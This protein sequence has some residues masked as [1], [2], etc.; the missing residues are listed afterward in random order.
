MP[1]GRFTGVI[2]LRFKSHG[3]SI[4][5][6]VNVPLTAKITGDLA[7]IPSL[8]LL[9]A[10][11][12]KTESTQLKITSKKKLLITLLTYQ[13]PSGVKVESSSTAAGPLELTVS[14]NAFKASP[15]GLASGSLLLHLKTDKEWVLRIPYIASSSQ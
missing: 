2:P 5:G 3:K 4:L 8:I 11:P 6:G 12:D 7:A 9:K 15:S 13:A 1:L 10:Q 14:F